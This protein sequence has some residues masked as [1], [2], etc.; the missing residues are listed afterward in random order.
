MKRIAILLALAASS[1]LCIVTAQQG[2]TREGGETVARPKSK[3]APK[4]AEQP[5]IPTQFGK[6]PDLPEGAPTFRSDVTT[7][8]VDVAVLDN[9]GR[10]IPN[11]PKGNFR[12]LEDNVPQQIQTFE[13]GESGMTVCLVVEFSNL[14]QY[15]WGETWYQTLTA[16]YGFVQTLRKEDWCAIVAYDMRP[17]ILMDFTQN[18]DAAQG[19]LVGLQEGLQRRQAERAIVYPLPIREKVE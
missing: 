5:K 1:W 8:N 7:V 15:Y 10:F 12:I 4:E 11:I 6:K 16:S 13:L 2:P 9:R 18:K 19:A 3:D 17:E 14:F